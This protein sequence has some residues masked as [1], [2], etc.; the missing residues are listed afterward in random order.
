MLVKI[1]NLLNPAQLQQ[2]RRL[3]DKADFIDGKL[4]AGKTAADIKNNVELDP[5]SD[6]IQALNQMV[7]NPLVKHPIYRAA[8]WPVRIATPFYAR[9]EAGMHYGF[10]VDDP[11]M[12]GNAPYR[13]DVSITVFLS[14]IDEYEGG[15]LEIRDTYGSRKIKLAAGSA[16]M[17]PSTSLHQVC[18]ITQGTR[19]VAVTW[20]QSAVRD[21]AQREILFQLNQAREALIE[22]GE[23]PTVSKTL[24]ASFNN[25]VRM[26]TD[27]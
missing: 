17:Y 21:P 19:L 10:H 24:N 12:G 14:E 2:I 15:E 5:N 7:M 6:R 26:W 18:E 16:V 11:V 20:A 22:S 8:V 3:L 13:T 1:E 9:Y 23:A 25:L 4:S 27:I